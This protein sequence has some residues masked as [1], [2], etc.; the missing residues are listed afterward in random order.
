VA[1]NGEGIME[2]FHQKIFTIFQTLETRD[3]LESV[4]AG[5]AIV[6]KI[7]EENGG[8][9]WVESK[10]KQGAKFYFKWLIDANNKNV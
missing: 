3:K 4:G 5:L 2:E 10:P 7:L 9:I 8:A 1:D 6:K